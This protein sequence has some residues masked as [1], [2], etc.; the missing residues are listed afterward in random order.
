MNLDKFN[1]SKLRESASS[2]FALLDVN[3]DEPAH[4]QLHAAAAYF[5]LLCEHHDLPP[6]D[7]FIAT[8][9]LM[10]HAEGPRPEFRAI[11]AYMEG[12]L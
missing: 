4:I 9:N 3:Q 5:L 11:R 10:N 8:K 12:E 2:A 6:Q 1:N 7:V